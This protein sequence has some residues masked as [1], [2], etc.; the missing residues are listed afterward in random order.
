MPKFGNNRFKFKGEIGKMK[1]SVFK[2]VFALV[3]C[4]MSYAA[5]AQGEDVYYTGRIDTLMLK[6][7]YFDFDRKVFVR[8]PAVYDVLDTTIFDVV[9]T[10]DAQIME[11]F[12]MECSW[13]VFINPNGKSRIF[14]GVC[15]PQEDSYTR[16]D[17]FLPADSATIKSYDGHGGHS[18]DLANFVKNEL[19][20]YIR[21]HYRTT[22]HSLG[23]GHSLGA[24]FLLQCLMTNDPFTDYFFLS[25]NLTFGKDKLMLATQFVNYT[26]D[27][28]KKRYLFFSDAGEERQRHGWKSWKPARDMV[29]HY[30]DE[31]H[32]PSNVTWKRK[33]YLDYEHWSSFPYALHDAYEGYFEYLKSVK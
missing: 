9:Y 8:L 16:Q 21:S 27:K 7:K 14:V 13:P 22:G 30:L 28:N 10:F 32:L 1:Q 20:P 33:S 18:A 15:S 12:Y 11:Q 6:S 5:N 3:A 26:F 23:I 2:I 31:Q 29:Y 17:D 25:P 19:Q 4:V 24:S